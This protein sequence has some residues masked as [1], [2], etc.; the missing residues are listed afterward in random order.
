MAAL[1]V[2]DLAE[3]DV[4]AIQPGGGDGGDEE[5]GAVAV[6]INVSKVGQKMGRGSKIGRGSS[7]ETADL[8]VGTSVGHGEQEGLLVLLLEV[9]IGKLLAVDGLA[10]SALYNGSAMFSSRCKLFRGMESFRSVVLTLPRVKSP[11]W[12]MNSG[13]MRWNEEPL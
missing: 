8:R 13:M 12:S 7:G 3:D 4:A 6:D 5:L 1:G 10:T 9:L 11:P 2:R